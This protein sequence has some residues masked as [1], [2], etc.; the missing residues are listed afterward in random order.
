MDEE[1]GGLVDG[2]VK[3]QA[4]VVAGP[5]TRAL[6][7]QSHLEGRMTGALFPPPSERSLNSWYLRPHPKKI[8]GR[9]ENTQ[10][11]LHQVRVALI[12]EV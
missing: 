5:M 8:F 12:L 6:Q 10:L 7:T 11:R 4:V 9:S 3:R 1:K 2:G